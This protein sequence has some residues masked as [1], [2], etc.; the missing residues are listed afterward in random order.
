MKKY[1]QLIYKNKIKKIKLFDVL[2]DDIHSMGE[3][4]KPHTIDGSVGLSY[5]EVWEWISEGGDWYF[6]VT[7]HKNPE[8]VFMRGTTY[9]SMNTVR[10]GEE[11]LVVGHATEAELSDVSK[12]LQIKRREEFK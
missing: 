2:I 4:S 10:N 12:K 11:E 5:H 1:K 9:S 3:G 7:E 8:N 6:V